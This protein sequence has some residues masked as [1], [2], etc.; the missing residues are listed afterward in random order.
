MRIY[1]PDNKE[2]SQDLRKAM[3]KEE[4]HLWYDC[5]RDLPVTFYR[6]KPI[7]SYIVDFYCPNAQLIVELDGSQHY[8]EKQENYDK[9]RDA[10]L[11]SMG[12][13]VKRYTNLEIRKNFRGVCLDILNFVEGEK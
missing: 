12:F 9:E 11:R 4:R 1:N 2:R 13:T 8:E 5:L 7:G 6:Q 10:A 3:T